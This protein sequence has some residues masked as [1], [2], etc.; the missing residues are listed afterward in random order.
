[1]KTEAMA[2]VCIQNAKMM[3][4]QMAIKSVYIIA[5]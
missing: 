4:F 3:S 2:N 1:M 5:T